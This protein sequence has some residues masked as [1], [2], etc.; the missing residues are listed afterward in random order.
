MTR[1][2]ERGKQKGERKKKREKKKEKKKN[3]M[4]KN[5]TVAQG[6]RRTEHLFY[7]NKIKTN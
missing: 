6:V 4:L 2:G 1:H 3:S 5:N 7:A